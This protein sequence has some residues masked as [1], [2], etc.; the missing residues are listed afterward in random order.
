MNDSSRTAVHGAPETAPIDPDAPAST[1]HPCAEQLA[2]SESRYL[3]TARL[4]T[5]LERVLSVNLKLHGKEQI[6]GGQ[7][8]LFNHFARFETFIPQYFIYRESGAYSRSI[9]SSEFFAPQDPFSDYLLSVGAVPN[10]L[11]G[12]LPFLAREA[13]NGRKVVVFPEGG[14][15]KDR[16]VVDE[17]G[18]YAVYS[19]T[20][21]KRRKHH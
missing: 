18:R 21:E 5:M 2:I 10:R 13:I 15:V 20:A 7:I 16:R 4:F 11:P 1:W 17:H 6:E 8:F 3:W 12:L 9:A 19:R 14:I